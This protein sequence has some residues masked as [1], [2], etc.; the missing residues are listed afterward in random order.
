[1]TQVHTD[2]SDVLYDGPTGA[3]R[4]DPGDQGRVLVADTRAA[5]VKWITGSR[6]GQMDLVEQ[7]DLTSVDP[8]PMDTVAAHLGESL[9][10]FDDA[11][12]RKAEAILEKMA[13]AGET[14]RLGL[15]SEEAVDWVAGRLR[16]MGSFRERTAH[17]D[18][19][20]A[21]D[22]ILMATHR[23]LHDAA[24]SMEDDDD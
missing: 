10:Y 9:A 23:V 14:D 16:N 19:D 6:A 15:I 22:L 3:G 24:A 4:P 2:G 21:N 1:M 20:E 11:P 8:Q 7:G 18:P 13:E 5:H 12:G 17:L